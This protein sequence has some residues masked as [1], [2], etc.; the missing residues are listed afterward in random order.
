MS[1]DVYCNCSEWPV[2]R[3]RVAA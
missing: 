1:I 3:W 2:R